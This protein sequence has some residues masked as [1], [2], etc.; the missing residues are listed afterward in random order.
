MRWLSIR[1]KDG[2]EDPY[3]VGFSTHTVARVYIAGEAKY[4]AWR[5]TKERGELLGVFDSQA[6][7]KMACE[8]DK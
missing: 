8:E 5:F 7:A 2:S 3:A 1:R 6:A 4:Q